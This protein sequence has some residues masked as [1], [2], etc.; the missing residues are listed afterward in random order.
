[1]SPG[2]KVSQQR[3]FS[4]HT[5]IFIRLGFMF[6]LS[7]NFSFLFGQTDVKRLDDYTLKIAIVGPSDEIFIWWGHAALIVE[8]TRW[9]FSRVYDWGIFFYPSDNFLEDFIKNNV[10]YEVTTGSYNLNDYI[11]EDRDVTVYTLDMDR[12]GKE[13]MLSYAENIVLPENCKY[14]Y[15]EFRDNC[16]TGIRDIIDLGTRGQ[17]KSTFDNIPGR[18]S[19]RQHIRRFTWSRPLP[20]W[21]LGFLMGRDLDRQITAWDEMFLPVEIARNIVDFKYLDDYGAERR[22]VSFTEILNS[23]KDR[24]PVLNKDLVTWPFFLTAGLIC[25][26]LLF[27]LDSRRKIYPRL[28]VLWGPIQSILGM[29]LGLSGCVLT[30]GLFFMSNDYI[31]QNFNIFFVNPLLLLIVPLGILC[32]A[33]KSFLLNTE[34]CLRVLW[35]YVFISGSVTMLI[36][37]LP[38]LNQQNQSVYGLILPIAFALSGI[39]EKKYKLKALARKIKRSFT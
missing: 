3:R 22:L 37:I 33:N 14:D 31:Q 29:I 23:S 4:S 21:F 10:H 5:N 27:F 2:N 18:F 1:M 13:L 38:F 19:Y 34:K 11:R 12:P 24:T 26:A 9:N 6:I 7:F 16:S 35:S 15:H 8:D 25:A 20:D 39:T 28:R 36:N 32:A 17:F 30:L